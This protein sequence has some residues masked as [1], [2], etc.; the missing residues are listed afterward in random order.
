MH[1][2][3]EAPP[4]MPGCV[5]SG[6][7]LLLP[8][9]YAMK[10][11]GGTKESSSGGSLMNSML[12]LE[13]SSDSSTWCY[14][15]L[16]RQPW[17][18]RAIQEKLRVE[19][20]QTIA[21]GPLASEAS[22]PDR[23]TK[24]ASAKALPPAATIKKQSVKKMS[25]K[26]TAT[27]DEILAESPLNRITQSCIGLG[28]VTHVRFK[29]NMNKNDIN[30]VVLNEFSST[31]GCIPSTAASVP[32]RPMSRGSTPPVPPVSTQTHSWSTAPTKNQDA[33]WNFELNTV[34]PSMFAR[35]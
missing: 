26:E 15:S 18:Y 1:S 29:P 14:P 25:E 34:M 21:S 32:V 28:N 8:S 16:Q 31:V 35:L 24:A 12:P 23:V 3:L 17:S 7:A 22:G 33:V 27:L 4:P 30:T 6:Q 13:S 19:Q 9:D 11:D 20:G 10:C 5:S 2:I